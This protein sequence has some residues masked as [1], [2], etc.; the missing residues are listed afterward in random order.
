MIHLLQIAE[1][2][3]TP[4]PHAD[5]VAV[6]IDL[7]TTNSAV[8]LWK[9]GAPQLVLNALGKELT[10]SA[11][12]IAKGGQTWVGGNGMQCWFARDENPQVIDILLAHGADALARN[13]AGRT[14]ADL[15]RSQREQDA[16][17]DGD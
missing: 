6:G 4:L 8:A 17:G 15:A 7:G 13:A 9:D 5:T 16:S 11:V 12:S 1:P 2:G 10:P 14:P 3:E